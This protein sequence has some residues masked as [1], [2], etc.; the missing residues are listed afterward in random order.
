MCTLLLGGLCC[1]CRG[2]CFCCCCFPLPQSCAACWGRQAGGR[3]G[4]REGLV[5]RFG[6]VARGVVE[7]D[8]DFWSV[9]AVAEEHSGK[10]G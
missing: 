9:A 4:C 8:G 6:G 3:T 1:C 5:E 7:R 10:R 2:C